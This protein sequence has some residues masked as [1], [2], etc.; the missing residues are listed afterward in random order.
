[1]KL[2]PAGSQKL[3]VTSTLCCVFSGLFTLLLE[4]FG[5]KGLQVEEIYDIS[6]SA[7]EKTFGFILL[8]RWMEERRARRQ[9]SD[10]DSFLMD[11][12][13][14]NSIFF[15]QQ[16]CECGLEILDPWYHLHTDRTLQNTMLLLNG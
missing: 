2:N 10:K 4:D 15:A 8:F 6:K 7:D 1:M 5:V 3:S 9:T 11:E 13:E 14:V 12:E 16:V